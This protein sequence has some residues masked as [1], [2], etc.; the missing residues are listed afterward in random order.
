MTNI[1][2]IKK[3][4][5]LKKEN[6]V[7]TIEKQT[8]SEET[9]KNI[10][11][12]EGLLSEA[13]KKGKRTTIID[14][15]VELLA[16]DEKYQTPLRTGRKLNYLIN[17]FD[18]NRLLPLTVVPHSEEGK[19]YVV[20]GYGRLKAS[21]IVNPEKY[22]TLECLVILTAPE[23]PDARRCFEANEFRCQ[24]EGISAVR[25]LHKHGANLCLHDPA[26]IAIEE[27]KEK[28]GFT[29]VKE[30]GN[31]DCN[32][33]GSYYHLYSICKAYGKEC[34]DWIFEVCQKARF[35]EKKNGYSS[36][37]M[38]SLKDIWRY[39]PENRE[40][41]SDWIGRWLREREPVRFKA[42]A[43]ARYE[44]LAERL[45]CSLYLEDLIVDNIDLN[46][47]R[48]VEGR[49]VTVISGGKRTA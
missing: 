4:V 21:Q 16:I 25:P 26:A 23:E 39:Y 3:A 11:K 8:L 37:I 5:N 7:E 46:H 45:A 6:T 27:L 29:F 43:S 34:A 49:T 30:K 41:L 10:G 32:V 20:D 38:S 14:I 17:N 40:E 33:L 1:T 42:K 24:T 44:L 35:N 47:V 36:Y 22:K 31:R 9:L 12:L 15:P 13:R 48:T 18:D 28:Y 19:A 2:E